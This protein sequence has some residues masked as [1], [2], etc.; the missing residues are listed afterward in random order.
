MQAQSFFIQQILLGVLL[1][2]VSCGVSFL[3]LKKFLKKHIL[4]MS[5][6]IGFMA[7][8]S[9]L[10]S[11]RLPPLTIQQWLP[12]L[13]T[14][15][16]GLTLLEHSIPILKQQAWLRWLTRLILFNLWLFQLFGPFLKGSLL[17]PA[18]WGI[19]DLILNFII[20]SLFIMV[21]WWM[22][23]RLSVRTQTKDKLE[24]TLLPTALVLVGTASSVSIALSHSLVTA[25][26]SGALTAALGAI[27]VIT[28][29]WGDAELAPSA[30]PVIA[31]VQAAL[32]LNAY[33]FAALPWYTTLLIV[34]SP[35]I[36]FLQLNPIRV[37]EW[38]SRLLAY[39]TPLTIVAAV[40]IYLSYMAA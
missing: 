20:I 8:Y 38:L 22:L 15:S 39:I 18:R 36:L 30:I 10:S 26:L 33:Y 23:E 31:I 5:L 28:W 17:R 9:G 35:S 14:A 19:N 4:T 32:L 40:S 34:A 24:R 12:Y 13:I 29:L 2:A 6:V 3:I 37:P 11:F 7:A 1:P 21:F 25:Q 16:L 27:M